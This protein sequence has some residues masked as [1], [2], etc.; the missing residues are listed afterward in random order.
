MA[1]LVKGIGITVIMLIAFFG[2]SFVAM[3]QPIVL[4]NIT[5]QA[6]N[7]GTITATF[8][9]SNGVNQTITTSGTTPLTEQ[10]PNG[11]HIWVTA[12]ANY[13]YVFTSMNDTDADDAMWAV[14][15]VEFDLGNHY[16]VTWTSPN[17]VDANAN[18]YV[19]ANF[20]LN[21]VFSETFNAYPSNDGTISAIYTD[22]GVNYT[23]T[24]N[25]AQIPNGDPIFVTATP[26]SGFH[27]V[28][29][30]DTDAD[31]A[32]W[33]VNSVEIDQA[34]D[35]SVTTTSPNEVD[36]N[37]NMYISA[38][39]AA[40]QIS[41]TPIQIANILSPSVATQTSFIMP[42]NL[43]L[44][45][46]DAASETASIQVTANSTV[47]FTGTATLT[48]GQTQM[49]PCYFNTSVLPIGNYVL[50][51][52]VT[53]TSM[54]GATPQT[55]TAQTGVT[56]LGDLNGDFTVNFRDLVTF[57]VDYIANSKTGILNASIDFSHNGTMNL[58]DIF[59]FLSYYD[60]FY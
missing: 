35:Y 34:Y 36:A 3:A 9:N 37:S 31:D 38:N 45:N 7:G 16:S 25:T 28:S 51:A 4:F 44:T 20:V 5:F 52:T 10:I 13:G 1:K 47:V 18:M 26:N 6:T 24:S 14:N 57:A 12:T 49:V 50:T 27:F 11:N 22:N 48:S 2:A 58:L 53:T 17:E 33:A 60:S 15:S 46:P 29:M 55:L 56:Y 59:L 30:N 39:F 23:V 32:M 19:Y 41:N 40:N 21:A 8:T 42:L 43:I 54:T